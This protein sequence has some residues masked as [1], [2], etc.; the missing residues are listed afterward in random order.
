MQAITVDGA[1]HDCLSLLYEGSDKLFLPVENIE[2]ITRY[3]SDDSSAQLDRLGAAGWQNRKS[4]VKKKILEV[5]DYLIKLAAERSLHRGEIIACS[6]E[7]LE[8][9]CSRFPYAETDDQTK[10]IEDTLV[11]LSQ[12]KP[13]DRLVCG[14]VGFGK[15]EVALRA[16][17]ATVSSGKQVAVIVPT[18][19]LC[20]QHYATFSQRFEG[21]PYSVAQLSRFVSSKEAEKV[22]EGLKE[23]KINIVVATHGLLSEKIKF[24]DLGLLIVDEEQHF[25]VKQKE[26]LKQLRTD[27][28]VLTL[29]ATPIPRTLQ[30]ALTGVREMSLITTPPIDRLAVR[31]FVMPYD[32]V[33]IREAILREHYR[34]GQVFYVTPRLEDIEKL[35]EQLTQLVPEVK[36]GVAHGQMPTAQ[37]EDVMTAFYDRKYN[38]L[39]STNIVE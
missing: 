32:G 35:K 39:L 36:V 7:E 28:H 37:L 25:G 8:E 24:S 1:T 30:L 16:A 3:G 15:T 14:D 17:F 5:A 23:G 11:N 12:G 29:T 9:F 22:R 26:K 4:K 18:T 20:R 21:F 2:L 33:T 13:M 10:A 34:G 6:R 31:T 27:V 19:L 38:I